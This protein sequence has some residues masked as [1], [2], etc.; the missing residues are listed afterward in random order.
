MYKNMSNP[1]I[2]TDRL[3]IRIV[4]IMDYKAYFEF[5]SNKNVCK[6]LT[7]N[8]YISMSQ[9]KRAIENMIRSNLQELSSNFSIILNETNS[10]I[11]SISVTF[12]ENKTGEIGYILSEKY[13]N[14]KIMSEALD[15]FIKVCKIHFDLNIL[16]ACYVE[17]NIASEVLLSKNGFMNYQLIQ[18]RS[19]FL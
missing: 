5:C 10:V 19:L 3:T 16:T 15:A 17:D 9:A 1:I 4:D 7:F 12:K 11:G 6:Y 14:Q 2:K 13:W 18:L 8:P